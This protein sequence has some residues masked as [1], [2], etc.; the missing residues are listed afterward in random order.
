MDLSRA[1]LERTQI[2]VAWADPDQTQS[3]QIPGQRRPV[4]DDDL[5]RTTLLPK[6]AF[7]EGA[8]LAVARV[9]EAMERTSVLNPVRVTAPVFVDDSGRRHRLLV[10]AAIVVALLCVA[11]IGVLWLS[12]LGS[13][14]ALDLGNGR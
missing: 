8:R 9:P 6:H 2:V 3:W 5:G 1:D 4:E 14:G 11:L 7:A 12:Q 13:G 10:A